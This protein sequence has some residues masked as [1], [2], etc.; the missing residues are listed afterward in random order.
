ML[1]HILLFWALCLLHFFQRQF[2]LVSCLLTIPHVQGFYWIWNHLSL[3]ILGWNQLTVIVGSGWFRW[4]IRFAIRI[5][6]V[7]L[8]LFFRWITVFLMINFN[9]FLLQ[10]LVNEEILVFRTRKYW[11]SVSGEV[12]RS[13]SLLWLSAS[14]CGILVEMKPLLQFLLSCHWDFCACT[15]MGAEVSISWYSRWKIASFFLLLHWIGGL[16]SRRL[17]RF[18]TSSSAAFGIIIFNRWSWSFIFL[19][20]VLDFRW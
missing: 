1:I 6:A 3:N 12:V 10:L 4:W 15:R 20:M 5:W 16:V 14:D 9:G 11:R 2:I 19:I 17:L 18:P 7:I 13:T 8:F